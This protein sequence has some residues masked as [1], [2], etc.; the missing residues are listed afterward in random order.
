V[1]EL[2]VA[3]HIVEIVTQV[4]SDENSPR[5]SV[6]HLEIGE[7][8]CVATSAL[9]FVFQAA[10]AGTT[11]EGARLEFETIPIVVHCAACNEDVPLPSIQR[12]RCPICDRPTSKVVRGRE[13]VVSRVEIEEAKTSADC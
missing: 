2:S 9:E 11:A 10:S 6:I 12:F 13:L 5:V 8:S 3:R 4:A 1:H 7:L